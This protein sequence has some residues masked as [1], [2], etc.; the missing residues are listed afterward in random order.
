MIEKTKLA[1]LALFVYNRLQHTRQTVEALQKNGLAKDSDLFIFSDG[2]K[3]EADKEKVKEVQDY[4]QTIFGFKSIT[5]T[6][7]S[8]NLGLSKSIITGVT[9]IINKYKKI[10]VLEDDLVTSPYFLKYMNEALNL[11]EK[12]ERVISIHGYIYPLKERLPETF[13]LRGADCWGWAT[14]KRGW[15]LFELD[16]KKLLKELKDKQ[17][18]KKFDFD[19]A[20]PFTQMLE[21]QTLGFND[22]WAIR[23]H[24]SAFL[25]NKMT[26]YPGCSLVKN[27]GFGESGTHTKTTFSF[28]SE[29]CDKPII[30][31]PIIH[32]SND[33]LTF[34]KNYFK[35]P[36][37]RIMTAMMRVKYFLKKFF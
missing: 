13:F 21:M 19:G 23:W 30:I 31:E 5:V 36:K 22:S 18:T 20:Y 1:P 17:L 7:R 26:L 3:K 32:E 37:L 2:P 16:G 14:W 8:E 29:M 25:A 10:I 33:I 27:I 6:K 11:Y 4:I 9:E 28:E 35:S 24:A 15:D 34:I 12:D